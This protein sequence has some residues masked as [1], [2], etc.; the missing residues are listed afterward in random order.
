LTNLLQPI[1]L[2]WLGAKRLLIVGNFLR[3]ISNFKLCFP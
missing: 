2:I 3:A 1:G